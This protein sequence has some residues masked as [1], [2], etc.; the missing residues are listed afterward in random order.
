MQTI[1]LHLTDE[2]I[3]FIHKIEDLNK[4]TGA[5]PITLETVIIELLTEKYKSLDA[6]VTTMLINQYKKINNKG[7]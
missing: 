7:E 2:I 5:G 4:M 1:T 3:T 6:I